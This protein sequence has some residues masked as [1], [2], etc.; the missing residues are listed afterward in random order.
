MTHVMKDPVIEAFLQGIQPE[1]NKIRDVYLFGSRAR[2]DHQPDSD[3][4]LLIVAKE[5]DLALKDRIYDVA[6]D[7]SLES[8]RDLSLKF[9]SAE[10]FDR[11][12]A[13]PSRFIRH[14]LTEG[15]KIG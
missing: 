14:V 4:D 6:T 3:Y 5:R 9:F 13:I 12:K 8:R 11:L 15:I 7:V 10:K 1:R 2:G